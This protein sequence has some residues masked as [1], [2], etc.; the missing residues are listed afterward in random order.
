[1]EVDCISK[2]KFV[3]N[4]ANK[5]TA[6][7]KKNNLVFRAKV[8]KTLRRV[9]SVFF[10]FFKNWILNYKD[11]NEKKLGIF[12]KKKSLGSAGSDR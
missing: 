9:G 6:K 2:H 8:L 1:M 4:Y 3:S 5:P 7:A 11:P 10:A 12:V